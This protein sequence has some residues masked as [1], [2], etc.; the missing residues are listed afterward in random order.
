[1]KVRLHSGKIV[2]AKRFKDL[3]PEEVLES[4]N[5]PDLWDGDEIFVSAEIEEHP[6]HW[7]Y[8]LDSQ[9]KIIEE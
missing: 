3:T 5:H 7:A 6:N 9:V 1:M 4:T 2:E 8:E